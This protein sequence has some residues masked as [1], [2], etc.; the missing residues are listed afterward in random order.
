MNV[1]QR[2]RRQCY[3]LGLLMFV[4][5]DSM[6]TSINRN[7]ALRKPLQH[8]SVTTLGR[9]CES[10]SAVHFR[11]WLSVS[12]SDRLRPHKRKGCWGYQQHIGAPLYSPLSVPPRPAASDWLSRTE[13]SGAA[14]AAL[15][16]PQRGCSA[17]C[18]RL[19][20]APYAVSCCV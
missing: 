15:S 16:F 14:V 10:V 7:F 17:P 6:G 1:P 5:A 3:E 19:P 13:P 8:Q 18:W 20:L 12:H 4:N 2:V 9:T 11:R